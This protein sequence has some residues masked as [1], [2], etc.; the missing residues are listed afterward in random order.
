MKLGFKADFHKGGKSGL[1]WARAWRVPL[2]PLR[3][4]Q[5]PIWTEQIPN[6]MRLLVRQ[7]SGM[8]EDVMF[9]EEEN[10]IKNKTGKI[11]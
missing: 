4:E 8:N 2:P 6:T 7:P 10:I 11:Y 3:S 9:G 1:G 5:P